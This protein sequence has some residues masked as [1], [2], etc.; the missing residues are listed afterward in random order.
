[1]LFKHNSLIDNYLWNSQEIFWTPYTLKVHSESTSIANPNNRYRED[2]WR[3]G[4]PTMHN[5]C[6]SHRKSPWVNSS[7]KR[8]YTPLWPSHVTKC[9]ARF[10]FYWIWTNLH[11][12]IKCF[13]MNFTLSV[14]PL[15]SVRKL[16][17]KSF[18][19]FEFPT[20]RVFRILS[21]KWE[22]AC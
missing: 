13:C 1:M 8:Y 4:L 2:I 10:P 15:G 16:S 22:L 20:E 12:N 17:R 3:Q 5:H 6:I 9:C 14:N 21:I 7:D 19:G 11:Y 18:T